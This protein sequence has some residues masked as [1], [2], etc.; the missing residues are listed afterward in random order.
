MTCK[1]C[2]CTDDN[3]CQLRIVICEDEPGGRRLALPGEPADGFRPCS[4]FL[5]ELCDAPACIERAYQ[6]AGRRV[7]ADFDRLMVI[8]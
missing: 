1:F 7:V 6:E 3:A 4:W 8:P 2:G 5:F